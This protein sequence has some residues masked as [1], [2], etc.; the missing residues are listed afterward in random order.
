MLIARSRE[1][2]KRNGIGEGYECESASN[3]RSAF[4]SRNHLK[5]FVKARHQESRSA[6]IGTTQSVMTSLILQLLM[7]S[8][9]GPHLSADLQ[10]RLRSGSPRAPPAHARL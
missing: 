1:M 2:L 6:P 7:R 10:S 5:F 9:A 4:I 8:W 3:Q